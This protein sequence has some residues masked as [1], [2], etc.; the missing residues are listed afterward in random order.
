[1]TNN[2]QIRTLILLTFFLLNFSQL[3]FSKNISLERIE[4]MFWWTGMQNPN[5]QLLVHGKNIA[6]V[7]V[8]IN[9]QGVNLSI[10]E[11]TPKS[12]LY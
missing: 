1:M 10:V 4:P 11:T 5:L 9:Y 3:S 2:K 6:Q 8:S 7:D 12:K